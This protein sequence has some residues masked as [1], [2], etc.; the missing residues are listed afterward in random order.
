MHSEGCKSAG[1]HYNPFGCQHGGPSDEERHVGDLG[2]ILVDQKGASVGTMV[3]HL[4]K[5]NGETSVLGR[6]VIVHEGRD[7]LGRGPGP[8]SKTTGNAGMRIACG[9]IKAVTK[10][11]LM[12]ILDNLKLS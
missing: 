12:L 10:K 2:N 5:L 6:S 4:V 9:E 1:P 8:E 3:D 7:D 11:R